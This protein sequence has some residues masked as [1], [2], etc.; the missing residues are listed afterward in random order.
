MPLMAEK[1]SKR[2]RPP[3]DD[4]LIVQVSV[5]LSPEW[6]QALDALCKSAR[7]KLRRADI[8]R[9]ALEDYLIA[10]GYGPDARDTDD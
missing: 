4:A 6:G 9:V 7:P 3:Q 5:R 10:K 2:G 8:V 1:K